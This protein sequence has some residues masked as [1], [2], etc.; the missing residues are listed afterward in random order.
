MIEK[1]APREAPEEM[2]RIYGSASGFW[3]VACITTPHTAS[4]TPMTAAMMT[5]GVRTFHTISYKVPCVRVSAS[6][7]ARRVVL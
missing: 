6:P 3:T 5:R 2:P 7:M 4:V 1:V